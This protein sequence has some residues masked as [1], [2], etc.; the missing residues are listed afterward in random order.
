M[1]RFHTPIPQSR[2][3]FFDCPKC[4]S[5]TIGSWC[6]ECNAITCCC[7]GFQCPVEAERIK[8]ENDAKRWQA[9]REMDQYGGE[10]AFY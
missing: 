4:G 7:T 8:D 9:E 2:K 1:S 10:E 5:T 3:P 6:D